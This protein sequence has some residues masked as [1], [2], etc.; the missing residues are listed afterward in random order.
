MNDRANY[1]IEITYNDTDNGYMH[2]RVFV[3]INALSRVNAVSHILSSTLSWIPFGTKITAI[4]VSRYMS[5]SRVFE[6][7]PK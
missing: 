1:K 6:V 4:N 3:V 2:T 5:T 7:T